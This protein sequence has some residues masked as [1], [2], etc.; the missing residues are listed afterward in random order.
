MAQPTATN[1]V[2]W[3]PEPAL[4]ASGHLPDLEQLAPDLKNLLGIGLDALLATRPPYLWSILGRPGSWR[5]RRNRFSEYSILNV[6]RPAR[7]ARIL[8]NVVIPS[9]PRTPPTFSPPLLRRLFWQPSVILQ[10]PDHHGSYTSFP[11]EA[12]FFVNGVASNDAVAQ[13]NSAY[14]SYLFHRPLT[15]I[16]NSTDSLL[17]DL[18]ECIG[19]KQWYRHTEAATKA[20]PPIY[21]ALKRPDK[22]RV[23]VIAHSQGTI[24]MAIV[25][26]MLAA[27]FSPPEE[28]E[29]ALA[30]LFGA[31][32][33][34]PPEF[35]YPDQDPWRPE[36]FEPLSEQE[37]AKLELYC[38][39]NCANSMKTIHVGAGV[40][41]IPWI[42]SFGNEND[43]VAR[44]G[45]LTPKPAQRGIDIDGPCYVKPNGWGHLLNAHYLSDIHD[46]QKVSRRRGGASGSIPYLLAN[47]DRYPD[48]QIPR[49]FSYINGGAPPSDS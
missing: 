41:P 28:P 49:L 46:C 23:V 5:P 11:D 24:I 6:W 18:L 10:R 38:F 32:G 7:A 33:Y 21:D 19:G 4:P 2:A 13:L 29:L 27:L 39:A 15:M 34:A 20:F 45:M 37:L 36:D 43:L 25:L 17:L 35:V 47:A 31:E 16:Q 14:L 26:R 9:A 22:R 8:A 42:E 30:A 40:R 1:A 12:W 3:Q 48:R 44:L